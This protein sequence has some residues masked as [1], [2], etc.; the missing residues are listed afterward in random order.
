VLSLLPAVS[1]SAVH[2]RQEAP[3]PVYFVAFGLTELLES[4][5]QFR[6][7]GAGLFGFLFNL[8][9]KRIEFSRPF[10]RN[11]SEPKNG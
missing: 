3:N 1:Q 7:R 2:Q 8:I 4:F 10:N 9:E 11:R 5:Q 6:R